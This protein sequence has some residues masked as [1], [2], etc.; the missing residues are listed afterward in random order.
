MADDPN[1]SRTVSSVASIDASV[2]AVERQ[3][4]LDRPSSWRCEAD[5]DHVMP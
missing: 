4:E 3:R 1:R 5:A 2:P